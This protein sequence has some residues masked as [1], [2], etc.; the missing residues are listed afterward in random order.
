MLSK[1]LF[2]GFFF[3]VVGTTIG[4][5][6]G[7]LLKIKSPKFLSFILEFAAGLMIAVVSLDL[8]PESFKLGGITNAIIFFLA[9]VVS[10]IYIENIVNKFNYKKNYGVLAKTGILVGIGLA[11]HNL[12]EGIAIGSGF[13]ASYKLGLSLALVIAF[14]DIP[15]GISMAVPLKAGGL[16]SLKVVIL[17][18]LSGIP[19]AFGAL[20]GVMVGNISNTAI[21]ACL[22]FAAGTMIYIVSGELM[23]K[24]NYM[25]KGRFPVVGNIL[26][27]VAGILV[28]RM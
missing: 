6:I 28:A 4:G 10:I 19:T 22:A 26:G 16:S 21:S 8:L 3:G 23:P 27:F 9:G 13:S 20:I 2:I 25:Y 18:F 1:V 17:T 7:V 14:H 11:L 24:S 15:E 5:L 12:P